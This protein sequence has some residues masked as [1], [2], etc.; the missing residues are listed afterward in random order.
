MMSNP[1]RLLLTSVLLLSQWG[2]VYAD[3]EPNALQR[4]QQ[5]GVLEVAVYQSLPPYSFREEGRIVG[6][7]ADVARALAAQ[8][9][10]AASIRAVGADENMEDDLR[11]N[12]WKGHYLGGGV[13]DLMLH[14]PFDP[15]FAQENDRALFLAP[16]FR[17]QL[18][19]AIGNLQGGRRA[20]PFE[21]FTEAKVG[22]ELDTLADFYLL[23]AYAGRIREQVVHFNN[24]TEAVAALK[25][26][27]LAGVVGPRGEVEFAIG[28]ARQDYSVGPVQMPGLRQTGWDLGGAVKVG[29]DALASALI[30]AMRAIRAD[31]TLA[32]IFEQYGITYQQPSR[33][34]DRIQVAD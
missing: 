18:V 14:V 11:N 1:L 21:L 28:D 9:G 23:S 7:D 13:A 25:A 33:L 5:K 34:D 10:V 32:T 26:G 8:L 27:E 20:D 3:D 2:G 31:G 29:N 30:D 22:V 24:Y 12:V 19:V 17:E 4:V 16:Y 6:V 15:E